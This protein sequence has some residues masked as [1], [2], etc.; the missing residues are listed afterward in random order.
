[1]I[2]G[3]SPM[4]EERTINEENFNSLLSW[5]D[6][7]PDAAARKYET[8]RSRLIRIYS[9][10][11]C[12]EAE[13]IADLTMDRVTLKAAELNGHYVGDPALYFYG[14]A[15]NVYL[16]WLRNQKRGRRLKSPDD[17]KGD[18]EEREKEY[19]CLERCLDAMPGNIREMIVE[20]Y[21]GEKRIRIEH[22]RRLA[23]QLGISP[24]ALQIKT[25][26]ISSRLAPCVRECVNGDRR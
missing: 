5:L 4:A 16:E 21:R 15:N 25:S 13:T 17:L 22:R 1:M 8:I 14:V 7:D 23:Q 12:F 11:G 2:F 26:R 6:S 18:P 19:R 24:G 3:A 10:R 9:A 20:Y